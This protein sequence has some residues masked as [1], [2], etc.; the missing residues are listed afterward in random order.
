VALMARFVGMSGSNRPVMIPCGCLPEGESGQLW[1]RRLELGVIGC[2]PLG[3]GRG[4]AGDEGVQ[5]KLEGLV[6]LGAS[7]ECGA[8]RLDKPG[9]GARHD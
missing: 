4:E 7:G 1:E 6:G 8:G 5:A 9:S 3:R 2:C